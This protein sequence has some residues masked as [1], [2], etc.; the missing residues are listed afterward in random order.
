LEPLA[1]VAG[2]FEL[3]IKAIGV[4]P[5]GNGLINDTFLVSL[6][7]LKDK[8]VILQR[9]NTRIFCRPELV[10]KNI[11]TYSQHIRDRQGLIPL[12]SGSRW[13]VPQI[14][15]T[16]AG[17]DH[18]IGPDGS[19]WRAMSFIEGARSYET[20]QDIGH[21]QEVGFALGMFHF[22]VKD[23][24][25]ES[26]AD[27]LEGFHITPHYLRHY[28]EVLAKTG[29][30]KSPEWAYSRQFINRR[31]TI[32]HVLEKAKKQGKLPLRPIHGDPK[33]N[34]VMIDIH[35]G[36][37]VGLVDLDTVKPGLIHYDIGDCLR[38]CCNLHKE[39]FKQWET[40]HFDLDYCRAVLKGYLSVARDFLK[41]SEY[42][43]LYDAVRLI[44]F[45][46]GL[47]FFTDHL[48]GNI[49]WKI[50]YEGQN[51]VRALVQFKL[52]ESIESQEADIQSLIRDLK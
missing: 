37:A 34:N 50:D 19:F 30:S 11:R 17:D 12:D 31:K 44:A 13:E 49:Y 16:K 2:H 52:T 10:M 43:Y 28:N 23:L 36:Q 47:R 42:D 20:I 27:T 39:D 48:E 15:L 25:V 46:L 38:S 9:V 29:L 24:P 8:H 5:Y 7:G 4:Q 1:V 32:V 41:E 14:F 3:P 6:E 40:V 45:E 33:V 21:A 26:L 22:L 35:T 18:W 51:L